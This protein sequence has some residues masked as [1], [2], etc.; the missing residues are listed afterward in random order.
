MNNVFSPTELRRDIDASIKIIDNVS[1]LAFNR[2]THIIF[3]FQQ[4]NVVHHK[5]SLQ[6][7]SKEETVMTDL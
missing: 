2:D 5:M 7:L 6:L 1:L 4:G 3:C